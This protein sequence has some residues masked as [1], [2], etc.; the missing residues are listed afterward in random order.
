MAFWNSFFS[1]FSMFGANAT[2]VERGGQNPFP[3][4]ISTTT[5]I[6]EDVALKLSTVFRCV[7]ITNN[8]IGSTPVKVTVDGVE[9]KDDL[10]DLLNNKPNPTQSAQEFFE[11]MCLNYLLHGNAYA[12]IGRNV[13][14]DVV[15]LWPIP[16]QSMAVNLDDDNELIY[17]YYENTMTETPI[18]L[19]QNEVLHIKQFGNG[20]TG[21][22]TIAYGAESFSMARS[23]DDYSKSFYTGGGKPSAVV[24]TDQILQDT[25]R[26]LFKRNIATDSSKQGT[27]LLEA[28]FK[29]K[30][31]QLSPADMET[32]ANRKY[33]TEDV[34]RW[35]GVP[36]ALLGIGEYAN[37]RA[38]GVEESIRGWL[39]T[40]LQPLLR[41][42]EN[43][44]RTQLLSVTQRR[45]TEINFDVYQ[46]L[47]YD[48]GTLMDI[49]E[50]GVRNGIMTQNESRKLINLPPMDGEDYNTLKQQAQMVSTTDEDDNG[51]SNQTD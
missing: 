39:M 13:V 10:W 23:A 4:S 42:F 11:N 5:H 30:Q 28:G 17:Q 24:E 50:K 26:D 12:R 6:D 8:M 43:G 34:A 38:N 2:K 1:Y 45:N 41:R 32:L 15:A 20:L 29:Y 16:A 40:D 14:G 48:I 37:D 3:D 9:V 35:F 21:V 36:L 25:H 47:Q 46:I 49:G 44:F 27:M 18:T 7:S 33:Q 19:S 22:S 51:T 31:I